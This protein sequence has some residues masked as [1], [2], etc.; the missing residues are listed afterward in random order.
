MPI[1]AS[2]LK[3][4]VEAANRLDMSGEPT[5][6]RDLLAALTIPKTEIA[7][8]A[9]HLLNERDEFDLYRGQDYALITPKQIGYV[10]THLGW[11]AFIAAQRPSL[12]KTEEAPGNSRQSTAIEERAQVA[13]ALDKRLKERDVQERAAIELLAWAWASWGDSWEGASI[14]DMLERFIP[15]D[16]SWAAFSETT[17]ELDYLRKILEAPGPLPAMAPAFRNN[18]GTIPSIAL[19]RGALRHLIT[20][21][22]GD[23]RYWPEA[24]FEWA[25]SSPGHVMFTLHESPTGGTPAQL[26]AAWD[27]VDSINEWVGVTLATVAAIYQH[28]KR[29]GGRLIVETNDFLKAWGKGTAKGFKAADKDRVNAALFTLSQIVVQRLE[30]THRPKGKRSKVSESVRTEHLLFLDRLGNNGRNIKWDIYLGAPLLQMMGHFPLQIADITEGSI[31]PDGNDPYRAR[32]DLLIPIEARARPAVF[33]QHGM[34][35]RELL[36]LLDIAPADIDPR[37]RTYWRKYLPELLNNSRCLE[38]WQFAE[39]PGTK[40]EQW[41]ETRVLLQVRRK[42]PQQGQQTTPPAV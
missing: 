3:A 24:R 10:I 38:M 17:L 30:Y 23:R 11:A 20:P 8:L 4:A 18:W 32:F 31:G 15:D 22:E 41:L 25:G 5:Q 33:T 40:W 12:S 42:P 36:E 34:P 21:W 6:A 27:H 1:R 14:A 37:K 26:Q 16:E 19:V 13:G 39:T 7:L 35:V 28:N 2:D 29:H 9:K